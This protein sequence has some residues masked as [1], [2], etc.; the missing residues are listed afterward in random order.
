[1]INIEPTRRLNPSEFI[2]R[3]DER[4]EHAC[5]IVSVIG[6]VDHMEPHEHVDGHF[7]LINSG[8]YETVAR[9]AGGLATAGSVIYNPPGTRHC[10]TLVKNGTL[11]TVSP[12]ATMLARLDAPLRE[13]F[14]RVLGARYATLIREILREATDTDRFSALAMETAC[15]E[16]LDATAPSRA[17]CPPPWIDRACAWL[18]DQSVNGAD[19]GQLAVEVGVHP[20]YLSR[21]FRRYVGLTPGAYA[22]RRRDQTARRLLARSR[23]TVSEVALGCGF[24]D[25][26]AFTKAFKRAT[27]LTPGAFRRRWRD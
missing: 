6:A 9:G 16:M 24:A 10:D 27:G 8:I 14:P 12:S 23:Q 21:A 3:L 17:S 18:E 22:R 11:V 4:H 25:Q 7:V 26:A 13:D 2:G 15:L 20:A 1:M 5:A 19:I